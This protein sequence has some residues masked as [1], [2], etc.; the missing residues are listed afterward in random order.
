VTAIK[1]RSRQC[2]RCALDG[3]QRFSHPPGTTFCEPC[4][5]RA[6]CQICNQVKATV[7]E[8]V[9]P[10]CMPGVEHRMIEERLHSKDRKQRTIKRDMVNGH[11]YMRTVHRCAAHTS[12]HRA[13]R[14]PA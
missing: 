13:G 10:D 7:L 1:Q 9:C 2:A 6:K 12:Q 3:I 14:R 11:G 4:R 8:D 5:N